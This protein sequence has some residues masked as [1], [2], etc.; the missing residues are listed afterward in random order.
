MRDIFWGMDCGRS[1]LIERVLQLL[2]LS[3]CMIG[4]ECG[5]GVW[6]PRGNG[7]YV[8]LSVSPEAAPDDALNGPGEGRCQWRSTAADSEGL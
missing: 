8:E 6:S 7:Y 1:A 3:Q 4:C 5:R 2:T